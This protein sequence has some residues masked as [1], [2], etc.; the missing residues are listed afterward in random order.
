M[1]NPCQRLLPLL[2][3]AW[4]LTLALPDAAPAQRQSEPTLEQRL[5]LGLQ[6]RRPSENDF[7]DAVVATVHRGELPQKLVDRTYFWARERS[8]KNGGRKH[9]RPIIYFQPA[10]ARQAEKLGVDITK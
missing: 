8:V 10:L 2:V 3:A 4:T 1:T 5:K 6:A 7:I 9:H